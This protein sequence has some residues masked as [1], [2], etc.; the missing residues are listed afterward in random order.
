MTMLGRT[1]TTTPSPSGKPIAFE[2]AAGN[3][4]RLPTSWGTARIHMAL[5]PLRAGLAAHRLS[6]RHDSLDLVRRQRGQ[7]RD[8][9]GEL[10]GVWRKCAAFCAATLGYRAFFRRKRGSF[11]SCAAHSPSAGCLGNRA[12]P[13]LSA[14]W[15]SKVSPSGDQK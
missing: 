11:E 2:R 3:T 8:H 6:Q 12:F 4:T 13:G 15:V 9:L 14:F 7:E 5:K 1:A 10:S